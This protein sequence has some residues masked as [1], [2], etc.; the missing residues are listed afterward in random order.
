VPPLPVLPLPPPLP[1]L[2]P[3]VLPGVAVPDDPEQEPT[4]EGLQVKPAPQSVSALQGSCHLKAHILVVVVVH[5]SSG[6]FGGGAPASSQGRS[7]G[8]AGGA[9]PAPP[10]QVVDFCS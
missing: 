9:T 4:T 6:G 1:V 8:Q 2:P 3:P 10:E 7:D 5:I